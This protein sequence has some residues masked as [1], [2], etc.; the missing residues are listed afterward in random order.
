[1]SCVYS[2]SNDSLQLLPYV[3]D[4]RD[5]LCIFTSDV[6]RMASEADQQAFE[7]SVTKLKTESLPEGKSNILIQYNMLSR[8]RQ[9]TDMQQ[10]KL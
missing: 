6:K 7:R 5:G 8:E 10:F 9:S 3:S 1:M 2:V 4:F